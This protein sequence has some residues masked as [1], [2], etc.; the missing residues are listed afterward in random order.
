MKAIKRT[1]ASLLATLM[2]VSCFS[3]NVAFGADDY[4][5]EQAIA[6]S[7][8]NAASI[9]TG[10]ENGF[11]PS[12]TLTRAEAAAIVVRM[13]GVPESQVE[14]AKGNTLFTDVP[15][16]SWAAG[17]INA[18][19]SM[20]IISGVG[21]GLFQPDREVTVIEF[22]AMATRAL[23]AGKLVDSIG[24]WP[25]NYV[26][27]ASEEKL[28]EGVLKVYT[29]PATR[30]DVAFM[31]VNTLE[32]KMWE[33]SKVTNTNEVTYEK[34][35]HTIL[36]SVLEITEFESLTVAAVDT[37]ERTV[38]FEETTNP[39]IVNF[40]VVDTVEL[41]SLRA[42]HEVDVW[43]K[44]EDKEIIR[45]A[46]A[47]K[48]KTDSVKF[49][50]IVKIDTDENEMTLLVNGKEKK[51]DYKT[52]KTAGTDGVLGTA[53]DGEVV[54]LTFSLNTLGAAKAVTEP[55][56]GTLK[57]ADNMY[58]TKGNFHL[59]SLCSVRIIIFPFRLFCLFF[60]C[61]SYKHQ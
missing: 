52:T 1:I 25:T 49:T 42:G 7:K 13:K 26:N 31:V 48:A 16:S 6:V 29:A 11:E 24:T 30:M 33:K 61:F 35:N 32:A 43:V 40:D 60:F 55:A 23:G 46:P 14:S 37:K 9:M 50:K 4:T 34:T 36:G 28:L 53:D 12:K 3:F 56:A 15:A 38:T 22:V 18:A 41:A 17:Y 59:S 44:A 51:Y 5:D 19:S 57:N 54:D 47:E 8:V 27:F 2:F 10:T 45:I 58:L 39:S 20:N 21:N